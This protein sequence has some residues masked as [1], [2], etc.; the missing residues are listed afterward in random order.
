LV[1]LR[2]ILPTWFAPVVVRYD[3]ISARS[4]SNAPSV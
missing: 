3:S 1:L 4:S 2:Q